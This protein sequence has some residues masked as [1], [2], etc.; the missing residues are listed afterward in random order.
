MFEA[1]LNP[2]NQ[3]LSQN[4]T[5]NE[6]NGLPTTDFDIPNVQE[7][8]EN[9]TSEHDNTLIDTN[10]AELEWDIEELNDFRSQN[11]YL[12]DVTPIIQDMNT[13]FENNLDELNT[14][15]AEEILQ[16]I[17]NSTYVPNYYYQQQLNKANSDRSPYNL[18]TRNR[19]NYA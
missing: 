2:N 7:N 19:I 4:V 8:G 6:P 11:D 1:V 16:E 14:Q 17:E 10:D 5:I 3:D 18:R 15:D 13:S 9:S 12:F